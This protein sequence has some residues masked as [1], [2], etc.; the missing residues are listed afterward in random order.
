MKKKPKIEVFDNGPKFCDRFTVGTGEKIE[1][2]R[3]GG[4]HRTAGTGRS[5][6]RVRS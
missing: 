1:W 2:S 5:N 3:D 4:A 6:Q